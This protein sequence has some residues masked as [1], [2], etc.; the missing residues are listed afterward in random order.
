M[1]QTKDL[2]FTYD[3]KHQLSFPD[4]DCQKGEQWLLLG[5]SGSGKTTLLHILGGL[6]KPKNG[7]VIIDGKNI[8][9]LSSTALDEFRGK[10]IGIVFQKPHFVRALTVEENLMLA[11]QLAGQEVNKD[12]IYTLLN[13]LNVGHKFKAKTDNLSE[14]EKQRVAIARALVNKPA[15]I[16]ADEPTSALDDKNCQEVVE[17]LET[18]AKEAD[19]TLLIVTHDGRL[20]DLV[21]NQIQL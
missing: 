10:N 8:R 20:K 14:G 12:Y 16:L 19:A 7:Q 3:G 17:L 6:R 15:V 21:K 4:I 11:Q 13:K 9:Q 5:Q 1:L 18:Q 2:Q